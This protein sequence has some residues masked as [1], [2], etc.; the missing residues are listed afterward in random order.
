MQPSIID[1]VFV[2][3]RDKEF[4]DVIFT[5]KHPFGINLPKD[6]EFINDFIKN[7]KQQEQKL[8][9]YLKELD[10]KDLRKIIALMYYGRDNDMTYERALE[11]ASEKGR[12]DKGVLIQTIMGK[13]T[14]PLYLYMALSKLMSSGRSVGEL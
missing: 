12:D 6:A 5:D 10:I 8:E 9:N 7:S 14:L 1:Q 13:S 3:A 11:K 2:L 4:I